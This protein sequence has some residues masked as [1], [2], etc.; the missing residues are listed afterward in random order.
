MRN[1]CL[2][3]LAACF[4]AGISLGGCVAPDE[5]PDAERAAAK[6]T[7]QKVNSTADESQKRVDE[8]NAVLDGK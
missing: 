4:L 5:T 1:R 2:L 7:V 8:G 6:Q 3:V